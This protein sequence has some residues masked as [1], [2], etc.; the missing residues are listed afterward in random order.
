M[1]EAVHDKFV[2]ERRFKQ[3]PAKVFAAFSTEEGKARWFSG[4]NDAWEMVD[5]HFDFRTGGTEHLEGKW[6]SGTITRFDCSYHDIVRDSRIVY[7]YRM[8]LNGEPISV[9]LCS[10]E[11]LP[12]GDGTRLLHTEHGIYLDGYEDNGSRFHGISLQY[13][14]LGETLPD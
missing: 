5:R 9:N 4:P 14:K 3:G 8:K 10:I 1:A 11:L 13:D 6:Q 2:I 12:D 7:A